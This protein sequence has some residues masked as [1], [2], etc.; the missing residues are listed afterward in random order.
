[1]SVEE[2]LSATL[3]TGIPELVHSG[4]RMGSGAF[5]SVGQ[6][7]PCSVCSDSG[8]GDIHAGATCVP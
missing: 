6:F 1:M 2:V 4:A 7:T 3:S 5:V 8:A